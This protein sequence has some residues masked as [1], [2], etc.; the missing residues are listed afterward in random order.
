LS[1]A[2]I[3]NDYASAIGE[4]RYQY[5][6]GYSPKSSIGGYHEI[7]VQVRRADVKVSAKAG[8]YPLPT[9]LHVP[10]APPQ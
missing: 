8:Y 1:E 2:T 10:Q 6:L 9:P 3:E 5:T 7:N 4:A